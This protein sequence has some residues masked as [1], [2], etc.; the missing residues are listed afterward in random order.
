M[1]TR[2]S[3]S[4]W[5]APR[6]TGLGV[7]RGDPNV[8]CSHLSP[9]S[10][11]KGVCACPS[12]PQPLRFGPDR[13]RPPGSARS[14]RQDTGRWA[15]RVVAIVRDSLAQPEAATVKVTGRPDRRTRL[16]YPRAADT[17]KGIVPC[18]VEAIS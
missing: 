15:L 16:V 6:G 3:G 2:D 7:Y 18:P 9:A 12:T 13:L 8:L 11:L 17:R 4:Y 10:R 5:R 1:S 14:M